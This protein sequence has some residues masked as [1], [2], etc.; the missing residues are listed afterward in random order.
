MANQESE[1][2]MSKSTRD[3]FATTTAGVAEATTTAGQF[4][5]TNAYNYSV[6]GRAKLKAATTDVAMVAFTG[7]TFTNLVSGQ[8]TALFVMVDAAGVQTILQGKVVPT[9]SAA[10]YV[11]GAWE[12]P[13]DQPLHACVGAIVV[14]AAATFTVGTTDLSAANITPT[15]FDVCGDYGVPITY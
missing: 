8:Q 6:A 3:N 13:T 10:G 5:N 1:F 7:T 15:Y 9:S 14:K 11:A 4:K 2:E 12:W